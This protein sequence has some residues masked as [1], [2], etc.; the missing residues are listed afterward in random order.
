MNCQQRHARQRRIL[1]VD[2]EVSFT[3]LLKINLETTGHYVVQVENEPQLALPAALD[4]RPDLVLMDVIMPGF[5]GGDITN[6]FK[7]HSELV[8]IPIIYLSATVMQ[9]EVVERGGRFGGMR[10]LAKPIDLSALRECLEEHFAGC[11]S[12]AG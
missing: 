3:R 4:F 7:E 11:F 8:R 12:P 9:S 2:D 10:F 5:D 1:V 6:R